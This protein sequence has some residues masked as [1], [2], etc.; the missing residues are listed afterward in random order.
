MMNDIIS[1]QIMYVSTQHKLYAILAGDIVSDVSPWPGVSAMNGR[2]M[3][4]HMGDIY[5]PAGEGMVRITKNGDLIPMGIDLGTGLPTE[6][7]GSIIDIQ[8]TLSFMHILVAGTATSENVA[9]SIWSWSGEGW[10]QVV[11][12]EN[13]KRAVGMFYSRS[14]NRLF[15]LQ[16]DGTTLHVFLPDEASTSRKGTNQK[17]VSSAMIDTNVFYGDMRSVQKMWGEVE[18][19]GSF[20]AGTSVQVWYSTDET[21]PLS[22]ST[23]SATTTEWNYLGIVSN[24]RERLPLPG[25]SGVALRLRLVLQSS[26]NTST[27]MIEAVA[28]RYIPRIVQQFSW[29]M[30]V[31]LPTDCLYYRD[32]TQVEDYNQ[33]LWDTRLREICTSLVPV[34]FTDIDGRTFQVVVTSFSRRI[35]NVGMENCTD[36]LGDIAWNLNI[37][38]VVG[39]IL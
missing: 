23:W 1:S 15:I 2:A 24:T 30:T 14:L 27:P 17:Y 13:G 6:R 20:P 8:S 12:C 25:V 29:Q 4:N 19:M 28:V 33:E 16:N 36:L 22:T 35:S 11:S 39:D 37:L 7:A 10:H 5:S 26:V 9:S 32:G 38:Q 3:T 34:T 21:S 31:A 18:V